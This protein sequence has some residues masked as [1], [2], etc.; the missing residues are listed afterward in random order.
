MT[1][2]RKAQL[3]KNLQMMADAGASEDEIRQYAV[4]FKKKYDENQSTDS[5]TATGW[6]KDPT[7]NET[8]EYQSRECKWI[9]RKK[10]TTKE[11]NISDEPKYASSVKYLNDA[12]PNEIKGC[13][14]TVKDNKDTNTDVKNKPKVDTNIEKAEPKVDTNIEKAEPEDPTTV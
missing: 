5:N 9:A 11:Y 3:D 10:G 4:D 14:K 12:Y 7:G 2:E 8:W 1:P 6:L 13:K